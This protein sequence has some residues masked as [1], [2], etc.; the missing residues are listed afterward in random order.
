M[1][2]EFQ[3]MLDFLTLAPFF[4]IGAFVLTFAFVRVAQSDT[5][6]SWVSGKVDVWRA[7]QVGKIRSEMVADIG[8]FLR[9][10]QEGQLCP[11][12]QR[13][14]FRMLE[15]YYSKMERLYQTDNALQ[16]GSEGENV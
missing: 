1:F 5:L 10:R 13:I 11:R 16:V 14:Y 8:A 15:S 6:Y 2:G 12:E 3:K 4:I 9:G 7:K